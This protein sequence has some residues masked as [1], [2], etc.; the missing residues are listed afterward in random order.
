MDMGRAFDFD[1]DQSPRSIEHE[2]YLQAALGFPEKE[3]IVGCQVV[4]QGAKLLEDQG[5]QGRPVQLGV[6][7]QRTDGTNGPKHAGI[8]IIEFT[9]ANQFPFGLAREDRQKDPDKQIFQN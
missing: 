7:V 6:R 2:I 9:V 3:L 8:E 1:G 4:I 5:F